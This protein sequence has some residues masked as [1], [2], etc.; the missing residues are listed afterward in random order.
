MPL[1]ALPGIKL[2]LVAEA[3]SSVL[4]ATGTSEAQ[5]TSSPRKLR[6]WVLIMEQVVHPLL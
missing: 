5:G 6:L 2:L 1:P 4:P 3:Q